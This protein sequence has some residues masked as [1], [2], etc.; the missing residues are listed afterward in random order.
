MIF[1]KWMRRVWFLNCAGWAAI[2]IMTDV[3]DALLV[4]IA[5]WFMWYVWEEMN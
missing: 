4:S 1:Q 5:C 3:D 2:Y